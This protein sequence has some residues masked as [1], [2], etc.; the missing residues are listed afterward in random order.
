MTKGVTDP[1]W[2]PRKPSSSYRERNGSQSNFPSVKG[3]E[4]QQHDESSSLSKSKTDDL[5]SPSVLM[6][7]INESGKE[8]QATTSTSYQR[9]ID[10]AS[11]VG[12][13]NQKA[14]DLQ[15]IHRD[16]ESEQHWGSDFSDHE[17]KLAMDSLNYAEDNSTIDRPLARVP[18]KS[19][20]PH[21]DKLFL[22][23]D[24][25][26]KPT[27]TPKKRKKFTTPA[28]SSRQT[29]DAEPKRHKREQT[30]PDRTCQEDR[31]P[32]PAPSIKPGYPEWVYEFDPAFIAEFEDFAEFI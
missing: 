15:N 3:G 29:P 30:I 22:S 27:A 12:K 23:T 28:G 25:P 13:E 18:G 4:L 16:S 5:P 17:Y 8:K 32:A 7:N 11:T 6:A 10:E 19:P 9:N 1:A 20:I 31:V 24:S 2:N 21:D 14:N 26:E